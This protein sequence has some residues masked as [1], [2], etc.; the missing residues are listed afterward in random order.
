MDSFML[1]CKCYSKPWVVS[2]CDGWLYYITRNLTSP[3]LIRDSTSEINTPGALTTSGMCFKR[4]YKVTDL[5]LYTNV[6]LIL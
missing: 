4:K 6:F 5:S 3:L 2:I 1:Q